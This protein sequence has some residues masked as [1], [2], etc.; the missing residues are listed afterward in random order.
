MQG[1]V[2]NVPYFHEE[3]VFDVAQMLQIPFVTGD[4]RPESDCRITWGMRLGAMA[5]F[6]ETNN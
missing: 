6:L 2:N 5:T 4:I 3:E 1:T